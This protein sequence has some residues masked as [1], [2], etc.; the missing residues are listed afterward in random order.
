MTSSDIELRAIQEWPDMG[1]TL[2]DGCR[3]SA[4]VWLPEDATDDPVPVIL[5]YLPYRKR[6]GTTARDALTHPWF[7]K[8]GYASVRVD[9]RGNGDSHGLMTDEYSQQELS[10]AVEVINWLADQPWCS[11]AV[12]M[13]G[14]SWGGFN[15]LQVAALQ[16]EPLKAIIALC[17]TTDRYHDDIHYKGGALLN[18]N[19]GWSSQMWSYS[20]RPPDPA[21]RADW[22]EIWLERL[23]NEPHLIATWLQHQRRDAYWA[24]GSVCEDY[25]ALKAKVLAIGGWGDGYKNTAPALV[26]NVP[27][28][29]GI[30]GPWIH[31]YPHFAIP[32]P[33]IGFLQEALRWWDRWLKQDHNGA[34]SD[35]AYRHYLMDGAAPQRSYTK[36]PGRWIVDETLDWPKQ[37]LDLS[38]QG[39]AQGDDPFEIPVHSPQNCGM[40]GGEYFAFSAGP[41]MPG[42]QRVDDAYSA[43][44]DSAELGHDT[45]IVGAPQVALRLASD[46]PKAQIVVRL[47]H[48][49]PDGAA[50]RIS[51]GVLNLAH[52]LSHATPQNVPVDEDIDVVIT[53][54]HCA[55]R[56]PKGHKLR[57]A[58]STSYWPLL[59]P[60][61][62]AATVTLKA[63]HLDLNVRPTAQAAEW[64]FPEPVSE[65]AR[66]VEALREDSL[67]HVVET[68][69]D[70]G[71]VT[72]RIT[73]DNGKVRD[74]DHGLI[75]GSQSR[76]DWSI[77]PDDPLSAYAET[78]WTQ[79]VER[80]GTKMRTETFA[81]MTSDATHFDVQ[82]A[83]KAYENDELIYERSVSDRILRNF[84]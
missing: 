69:M 84:I 55:Y 52:H 76:E 4:R 11:G 8:R 61:A 63:G 60:Q 65:T 81:Q 75:S 83:I 7:A 35:P 73:R 10:D 80:N 68:D 22:R 74:S 71:R 62:V 44:F 3:L 58:V 9:M 78:H 33:R 19:F 49:L 53:L 43:C 31:K 26:Q 77:C 42:D 32:E 28:A 20:S 59:W 36:R 34:E 40:E 79:E 72:V 54:D 17:A 48:V 12:G 47:S 56:V 1:I 64:E 50:T 2:A 21:L 24:H 38:A 37:R 46:M 23:E 67:S 30:T 18:E 14:I 13:M 66:Q 51:F 5:E 16:P 25:S 70:T 82:G 27:D 41:E 45:D 39:L 29:K 57:I 6:D 15:S